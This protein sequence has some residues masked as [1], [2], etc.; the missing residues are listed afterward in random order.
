MWLTCV[1]LLYNWKGGR[2]LCSSSDMAQ[3]AFFKA[4]NSVHIED[5]YVLK[6]PFC[7]AHWPQN[8]AS[9]GLWWGNKWLHCASLLLHL[10]YFTISHT[11]SKWKAPTS[12]RIK[13]DEYLMSVFVYFLSSRDCLPWY[14]LKYIGQR[15]L[16]FG[17][18]LLL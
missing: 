5:T 1:R 13:R 4:I 8:A 17:S 2:L 18:L 15:A 3:R 6:S 9:E 12:L 16:P 11:H 10:S 14:L 7:C